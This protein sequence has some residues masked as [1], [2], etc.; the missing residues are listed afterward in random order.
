MQPK[1][2]LILHSRPVDAEI[3]FPL[4]Q[5]HDKVQILALF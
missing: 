2:R 5:L 3:A 1:K 4:L